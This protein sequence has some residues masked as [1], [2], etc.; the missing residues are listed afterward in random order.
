MLPLTVTRWIWPLRLAIWLARLLMV[1]ICWLTW[2]SMPFEIS[3]SW[4]ASPLMSIA[5]LAACSV[6]AAFAAVE[7][8]SAATSCQ[9][10]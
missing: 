8:G 9:A 7:L 10:L 4:V 2:V 3:F 1:V 6:K 5:R